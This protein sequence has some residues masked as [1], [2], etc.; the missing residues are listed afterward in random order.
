[1]GRDFFE[2]KSADVI[3]EI[4]SHESDVCFSDRNS[5][6]C[7]S[8]RL[9]SPLRGAPNLPTSNLHCHPPLGD[10]H[11][12][13]HR[14][15]APSKPP[16]S[17]SPRPQTIRERYGRLSQLPPEASTAT[18]SHPLI[19]PTLKGGYRPGAEY[20]H[21]GLRPESTNVT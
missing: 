9:C 21:E 19:T 14:A 15:A 13:R 11:P 3:G 18:D 4:L 1:M 17:R 7:S 2:D 6:T 20:Q 16:N 5:G 8:V 10:W 12:C